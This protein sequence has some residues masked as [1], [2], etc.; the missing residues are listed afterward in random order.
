MTITYSLAPEPIWYLVGLDGLAAGGAY[1]YTYR[2]LNKIQKKAVYLDAGG[3]EPWTNPIIFDL[4]GTQGPFYWEVDST[5]LEDT[6]YLEAWSANKDDPNAG[7][8]LLWTLDDFFP[9]GSGG[10]GDVTTYLS[11]VNYIANNQI[12]EHI[13]DQAGP[14]PTNL[15]IAPSNHKGFT[16]ALINPIVGTYGVVGP[17]IRFIKNNTSATDQLS[18]PLFPLGTPVLGSDVTPVQYIRYQ[19][20]NPGSAEAYKNF[21]FPITQKVNNLSNQAMTFTIWAAV[22]ASDVNI[23]IYLRQ[24]YGS[25]TATT[26]ES[27]ST[28]AQIGT[29]ALTT[30]WTQFV[31]N[32]TVANTSGNSIGT[33]GLQTDDDAVYIQVEMP[34]NVSCDVLFTKPSLYLGTVNPSQTFD[35]YDQIESITST[36][37]TGDIRTSFI[38][39]APQGWLM[40]ND[41]SIGNTGS[42]A[43]TTGA[44]TF[45]LYKTLWDGISNTYAPV[46]GGRGASSVADF[47][48]TKTLTMPLSLGRALAGAGNGAGLT[49]RA[50]AENNG[51]ESTSITLLAA[52]LPPHT[53]SGL[54]QTAA[55]ST[56]GPGAF[57]AFNNVPIN[58]GNGPGTSTPFSVG[59]VQPSIFMNVFIKL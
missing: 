16:P 40:M 43:T 47:L 59:V 35:D 53:H 26:P 5:N 11:L 7:A 49:P 15:V 56:S 1:L 10:G 24:Y 30:T 8:V 9:S 2:S 57:V 18:F 36:A 27:T 4:N 48:A 32:F 52:N 25:G 42:G 12:I 13:S 20:T 14:L 22:T 3:A 41:T 6:Y 33:P 34:L 23:A 28:R 31:I 21:Q 46:S 17:D 39:S 51:A 29:C 54:F 38:S 19:C 44:Y 45:Q 58:T 37:R 55:S 50:L